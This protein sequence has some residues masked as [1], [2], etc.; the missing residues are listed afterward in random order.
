MSHSGDLAVY[1][2][3]RGRDVGIDVEAMRPEL[4]DGVNAAS[5]FSAQEVAELRALPPEVRSEAFF[6]AWTQ[7]EAY[8]KACAFGLQLSLNSL[9]VSVTPGRPERV[10]SSDSSRWLL[11]SFRPADEYLAAVVAEH[12]DSELRFFTWNADARPEDS[13]PSCAC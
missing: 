3:S 11:Q 13:T 9:S 5:L 1:A 8:V 7:K 10:V 2:I 12:S 6:L 4:V